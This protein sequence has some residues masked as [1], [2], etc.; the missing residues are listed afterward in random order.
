VRAGRKQKKGGRKMAEKKNPGNF[1]SHNT[2]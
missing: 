2:N 1:N